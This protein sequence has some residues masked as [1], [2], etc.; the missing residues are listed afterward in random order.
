MFGL[1]VHQALGFGHNWKNKNGLFSKQKVK[2][3][4]EMVSERT[5]AALMLDCNNPE[6]KPSMFSISH[7]KI[8]QSR[9][10]E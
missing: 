10:L 6:V 7:K 2:S 3:E 1:N 5:K 4:L 8:L 9:T